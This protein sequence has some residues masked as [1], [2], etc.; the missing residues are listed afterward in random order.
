[1]TRTRRKGHR[2]H[3]WFSR[4]ITSQLVDRIHQLPDS[5]ESRYLKSEILSKYVS[6]ETAPS[7]VRRQ[8]AINKWLATE[9]DNAATNVRLANI[10][11]EYNILPRLPYDTFMETVRRFICDIIGEVPQV[12]ILLGSFSGGAS[13]SRSRLR[14]FPASKY[15]GE[16]HATQAASDLFFDNV[17]ELVPGWLIGGDLAITIVAGNSLFTV[18][19]NTEIDRVAAK[20][21]DI[22]M[23]IQK[24]LGRSI[25]H[26][27]RQRGINLND[28]SINRELARVG[29][30]DG[31]LATLDLS[32]AS[33][34]VSRELVFQV[35]PSA[36]FTLLDAC[37]S[38][39]TEIDGEWHRNEM[40]SSMG[41]GFTFELESL[42]FYAIARAVAYHRG[43][44]GT[45]SVYGDDIIV[46][47][48]MA[49]DL[50]FVLNLLG[51][52]LNADKSFWSGPFR[53]SC[54]GH[55][56]D[57]V[58]VTPFYVREPVDNVVQL[59]L[60]ANSLRRWASKSGGIIDPSVYPIWYWLKSMVPKQF[61][62]GGNLEST[63]QL[64]SYDEPSSRLSELSDRKCT[65]LGGYYH[66]LN[67]TW[68]RRSSP[69]SFMRA[70]TLA[71]SLDPRPVRTSERTVTSSLYRESRASRVIPRLSA[72]FLEEVAPGYCES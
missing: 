58:D 8:R 9:A 68:D 71:E 54:G 3:S 59:I 26:A 27:L 20:E 66:W 13:T 5:N 60:M 28:Q 37:R 41:N 34:S 44:S 24:G 33:D 42:L 11:G 49:Q 29:S 47:V 15:L 56:L 57:G 62:G 16:A 10:D 25:R 4:D 21:P 55:F 2:P 18:P 39:F 72:L 64:V 7:D 36:W 1:M 32:S 70:N 12:E 30:L 46:P 65:G 40:F 22:N 17:V 63:E 43:V 23:F 38:H 35:L 69:D 61:W 31:S 51:F 6:K 52:Q 67:A 14:S 48:G 50:G 19:K 53:E 45:I